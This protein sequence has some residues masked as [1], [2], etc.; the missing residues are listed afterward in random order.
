MFAPVLWC[1][2]FSGEIGGYR[3]NRACGRL[4]YPVCRGTDN[5]LFEQLQLYCKQSVYRSIHHSSQLHCYSDRSFYV[6]D[7]RIRKRMEDNMSLHVRHNGIYQWLNGL[8]C[9]R[10]FFSRYIIIAA[11]IIVLSTLQYVTSTYFR[12]KHPSFVLLVI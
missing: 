11:I 8:V 7:R 9:C 1:L 3:T 5:W 6:A 4:Y 2:R 10:C 12:L